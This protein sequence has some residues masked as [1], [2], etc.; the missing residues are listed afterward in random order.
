MAEPVAVAAPEQVEEQPKPKRK[1][2]RPKDYKPPE[3]KVEQ[4]FQEERV[5]EELGHIKKQID[6]LKHA[7]VRVK[8]DDNVFAQEQQE[9]QEE[10]PKLTPFEVRINR[11]RERRNS[12]ADLW[13]SHHSS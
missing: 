12:Y 2:G 11:M 7:E 3:V 9:E 8:A 1:V 6:T 13:T 10:E 5:L 4:V